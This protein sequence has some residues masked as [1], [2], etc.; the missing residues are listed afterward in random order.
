MHGGRGARWVALIALLVTAVVWAVG[1]WPAWRLRP[2][3]VVAAAAFLAIGLVSTSW[4][5][6]PRLTFARAATFVILIVT[7]TALA[8]AATSRT[9]AARGILWGIVGG[10][11]VVTALGLV[12]LALDHAAAVQPA[13]FDVPAR[14]RG[15]GQNPDTVSL[16]LALCLPIALWLHFAATS[17]REAAAALAALVGFDASIA[18]S[19]SRGAIVAGFAGALVV[20][21]LA[22]AR[23]R[24]RLLSAVAV[25][26]MTGAMIGVA[27]LPTSKGNATQPKA[28]AT[29]SVSGRSRSRD[30]STSDSTIPSRS[31]SAFR[32][33]AKPSR[34]TARSSA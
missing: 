1:L 13:T 4:S 19:G 26:A 22:P 30:I 5:V 17:R 16:L 21:V 3:V 23:T 27:L 34:L 10:A 11:A 20:A 8:A 12:A 29:P 2:S 33:R 14:Y 25:V 9:G 31:T 15:F 28:S 24:T 7:A 32:G 18:A 6:D